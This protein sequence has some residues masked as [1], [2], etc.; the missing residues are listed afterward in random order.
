MLMVVILDLSQADIVWFD[1][2]ETKVIA[3]LGRHNGQLQRRIRAL[4]GQTET[5]ILHFAAG[6]DFN[7]YL[8]DPYR[9]TLRPEWLATGANTRIFEGADL[10][11]I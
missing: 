10:S 11:V 1:A 2:Y 8:A 7:A 4:D 6:A 3:L 5:H 9:A